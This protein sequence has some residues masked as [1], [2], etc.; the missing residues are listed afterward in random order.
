[1]DMWTSTALLGEDLNRAAESRDR[2]AVSA[3]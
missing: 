1:M 2:S 3:V